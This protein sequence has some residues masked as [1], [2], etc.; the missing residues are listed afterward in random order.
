MLILRTGSGLE[1]SYSRRQ[2]ARILGVSLRQEGRLEQQAVTGLGNA[3]AN[4]TCGNPL[5]PLGAAVHL[6]ARA[7]LS[8][9][10]SAS[11]TSATPAAAT[12]APH[13]APAPPRT[14]SAAPLKS[15][16]GGTTPRIRSA[17]ISTPQHAG[18]DWLL[19]AVLFAMGA[20]AVWFMYSR[21]RP[22]SARSFR[23]GAGAIAGA[24]AGLVA[25]RGVLTDRR[26][27]AHPPEHA[28][29]AP[30]APEHHAAPVEVPAAAQDPG[31]RIAEGLAAFE[32]GGALAQEGDLAAAEAAY[33]RA[34]EHGHRSGATNLGVLLEQRGDL[35]GAEAAY[36]RADE[37]GD[38]AGAFNLGGLLAERN[39][40][41]GAEA[42]YRAADK[43]GDAAAAFSFG[44][45]LAERN[46]LAGA[47]AA[48]RRADERG[49]P[50]AGSNLGVLLEQRGDFAG[51]EAAYRRADER[52]DPNGAFN[53]GGLLAERNDH[54]GAEAAF[55]RAD[56]RGDA[57]GATNL[58]MLLEQRGDF[59][60]AVAAYRRGDQRGDAGAAFN[61]GVLLEGHDAA[62]AEAAYERAYERGHPELADMA[63]AAIIHLRGHA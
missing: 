13:H 25:L 27:E 30:P 45:L 9:F 38:A 52:G 22:Q 63:R 43:R 17:G 32:L 11:P 50:A 31:S 28:A 26:R 54:D 37:R 12:S 6:A 21:R 15:A 53:L 40:L 48:Y 59:A 8:L 55:R 33:R 4:G 36:R 19:L 10:A 16:T 34:D 24:G 7:A 18:V 44:G 42:A 1:H 51:A 47:E 35:A 14:R 2:V 58:G 49:H 23:R 5:A 3:S 46:D 29:P 60:G 39:D 20:T 56:Q 62:E 41:A 57:A 61:L